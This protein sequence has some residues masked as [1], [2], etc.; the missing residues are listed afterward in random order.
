[1]FG[2]AERLT[3]SQARVRFV[4]PFRYQYGYTHFPVSL[5][6]LHNEVSV[7]LMEDKK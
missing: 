3:A 1:V 7:G 5:G 2:A 4:E 6:L